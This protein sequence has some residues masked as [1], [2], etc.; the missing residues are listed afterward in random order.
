VTPGDAQTFGIVLSAS[1]L[2]LLAWRANL[3]AAA[4]AAATLVIYLT[5]YTPMKR[6]SSLATVVGAVP[7]ALPPLIG[8]AAS[9]GRISIGGVALFAI[10]FLWQIPH[11]MAIA[12]MY[13]DDYRTAGF[14][15]L[16]VIDPDGR[17]AGRQAVWYASALV[18]V[19]LVPAFVGLSGQL[20][21]AIA[22]V[23]GA[24]LLW[25]AVQFAR[26]RTDSSARWLFFGSIT[27]LPLL[28]IAMIGDRL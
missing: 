25:L 15:M 21:P 22:G 24:G 27:Y 1:G 17:R 19:S 16:P 11:F 3:L 7:G 6:R 5:V 10:V 26:N 2:V 20:Y 23:L 8:W 14:P 9:H 4:L 13:R 18:P 12:W 28:W